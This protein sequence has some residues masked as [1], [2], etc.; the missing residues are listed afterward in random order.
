MDDEARLEEMLEL[1]IELRGTSPSPTAVDLC[2]SCPELMEELSSRIREFET[3]EARLQAVGSRGR[4]TLSPDE[5]ARFGRETDYEL[6][7]VLGAGGMGVVYKA[8]DQKLRRIVAVKLIGLGSDA[9]SDAESRFR[10]EAESMA[11]L[12]GSANIVQVFQFDVWDGRPFFVMEHVPGRTLREQ[13]TGVP[14]PVTEATRLVET[15]ARAI[16]VAHKRGI[17]HRDL[18]PENI[19]IAAD[20]T[21]K[22]ADLGIAKHLD[23]QAEP[24]AVD[25]G[26]ESRIAREGAAASRSE[27][28]PGP[29][30]P[31]SNGHVVG[32]DHVDSTGSHPSR[33]SRTQAGQVLG[34]RL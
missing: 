28:T 5:M 31:T 4:P 30:H 24:S 1:Y 27:S 10:R 16:H 13:L 20:G 32:R 12:Q 7:E 15:I 3:T 23:D 21:P 2:S 8:R 14:W 29:G 17:V 18:K 25:P 19:L 26:H 34:T 11:E 22:V 6:L 33:H 9:G